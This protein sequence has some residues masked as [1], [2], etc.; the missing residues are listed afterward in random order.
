MAKLVGLA[1]LAGRRKTAPKRAPGPMLAKYGV[2]GRVAGRPSEAV[3]FYMHFF[4]FGYLAVFFIFG[5]LVVFERR[6][7]AL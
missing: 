3:E 2:I 7:R 4:I 5:Y 1:R 6:T